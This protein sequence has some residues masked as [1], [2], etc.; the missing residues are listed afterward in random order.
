MKNK[1]IIILFAILF[2]A[3]SACAGYGYML[4]YD[5][6]TKISQETNTPKVTYEYYLE[7][8]LVEQ[9]PSKTDENGNNYDFSRYVCD[10][11]MILN[12]DKDNWQYTISNETNGTCK[13]YFVKN[14]Y[15]VELTATNGLINGEDA[16]F[17]SSVQRET[18]G[19]FN[20]IPNEG[21]EFDGDITCS[22]DK[23]AIYDISTNILNINSISE[24]VACKINFNKRNL[25]L[26]IIVKNGTGTTT[27]NKE[28]GESISA[29]VQP[30]EGYQKPKISCTNKQE[31]LYED[32]RLTIQKLTDNSTCTI[33]FSKTP[34]ETYNLIIKDLPEEVIITSGNKK[35]SVA[36]GKDGKFSLKANDGYSILLDCN[37]VKPS[38]QKEDPDGTI[39]YTFL[40]VRRNITCNVNTQTTND[41]SNLDNGN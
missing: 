13:L 10:N 15:V 1:S 2:V 4:S 36:S 23:E 14:D 3:S 26:D 35:Q 24:N 6:T 40:G 38:V 21:Y 31:Y 30:N 22:N 29:I 28:Y 39:T 12:F 37:G 33:T 34:V 27:E 19:Q 5:K 18:D 32:N 16:T 11:N 41:S 9:M 17:T 7:D 25:K 20:I 8:E